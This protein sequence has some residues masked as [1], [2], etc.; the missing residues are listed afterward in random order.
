MPTLHP[1][2]SA[3]GRDVH[4]IG[5]RHYFGARS[6]SAARAGRWTFIRGTFLQTSRCSTTIPS[7]TSRVPRPYPE[8]Y[9]H[10]N[11]LNQAGLHQTNAPGAELRLLRPMVGMK[12][13][14][15]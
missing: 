8:E 11:H 7:F 2:L 10:L 5:H 12:R 15:R 1:I 9:R 3:H 4:R 13:W 14:S 6:R